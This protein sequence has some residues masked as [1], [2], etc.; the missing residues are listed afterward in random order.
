MELDLDWTRYFTGVIYMLRPDSVSTSALKQVA[1]DIGELIGSPL[2]DFSLA[3]DINGPSESHSYDMTEHFAVWVIN[4][5]NLMLAADEKRSANTIPNPTHRWHHQIRKNDRVTGYARST[6]SES[7]DLAL[8]Q[9]F[10]SEIA[11]NIDHAISLL[12]ELEQSATFIRDHDWVARLLV[13]PAYQ[14]HAFWLVSEQSDESFV[15]LIDGPPQ[16]DVISRKELIDLESFLALLGKLQPAR[17]LTA[18]VYPDF[19]AP[20]RS[21]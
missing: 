13:V 6:N 12:D 11:E 14:V 17:G 9:F 1:D 5:D 19:N 2:L 7:D 15:L 3:T 21:N 4:Y 20:K 18:S 8:C 10:D 16:L